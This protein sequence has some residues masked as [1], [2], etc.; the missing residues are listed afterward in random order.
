MSWE[1]DKMDKLKVSGTDYFLLPGTPGVIIGSR[2][3]INTQRLRR[4]LVRLQDAPRGAY[5][6]YVT[7]GAT[8]KAGHKTSPPWRM[9]LF[10]SEALNAVPVY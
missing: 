2:K 9:D 4:I 3:Q 10:D 6:L 7:F 5:C 8:P 1:A